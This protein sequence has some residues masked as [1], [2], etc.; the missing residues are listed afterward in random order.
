MAGALCSC[1][2]TIQ[3][4]HNYCEAALGGPPIIEGK[5]GRSKQFLELFTSTVL[6]V[7]LERK[8]SEPNLKLSFEKVI[9]NWYTLRVRQ[10]LRA[11]RL[12]MSVALRHPN[13]VVSL[14]DNAFKALSACRRFIQIS[15]A[16][17]KG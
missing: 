7:Q 14:W 10:S 16:F 2:G 11:K 4:D 6:L 17:P 9:G 5:I 3:L 1:L 8:P 15:S 13:K 12:I